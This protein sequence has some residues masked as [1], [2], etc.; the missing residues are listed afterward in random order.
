[1]MV[2]TFLTLS[3]RFAL[4]SFW[5]TTDSRCRGASP[6]YRGLRPPPTSACGQNNKNRAAPFSD[7]CLQYLTLRVVGGG[8]PNWALVRGSETKGASPSAKIDGSRSRA[9][10]GAKGVKNSDKGGCF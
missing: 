9:H 7:C 4:M 2:N 8:V 5:T 3:K 6:V 10:R 1:M